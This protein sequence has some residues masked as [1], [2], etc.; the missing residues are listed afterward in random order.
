MKYGTKIKIF[1]PKTKLFTLLIHIVLHGLM[2]N[3]IFVSLL[4]VDILYDSVFDLLDW[5]GK[6]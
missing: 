1:F 3:D 2:K 4:I 6:D 5:S